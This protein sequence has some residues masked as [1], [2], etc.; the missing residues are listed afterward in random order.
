VH[1][2]FVDIV[3]DN[4]KKKEKEGKF[5]HYLARVVSFKKENYP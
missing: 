3:G 2:P 1:I 4:E 5:S